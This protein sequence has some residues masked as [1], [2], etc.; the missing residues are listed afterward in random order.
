MR[1]TNIQKPKNKNQ[2][3][4]GGGEPKKNSIGAFGK[5]KPMHIRCIFELG[6]N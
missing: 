2:F 4:F 3:N 6:Q 1:N 5:E